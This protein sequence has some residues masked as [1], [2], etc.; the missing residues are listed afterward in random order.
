[1]KI[2]K[3]TN[4]LKKSNTIDGPKKLSLGSLYFIGSPVKMF[5]GSGIIA[6]PI[7]IKQD[8]ITFYFIC[9]Y[10]HHVLKSSNKSVVIFPLNR[11]KF[12]ATVIRI[13]N[14]RINREAVGIIFNAFAEKSTSMSKAISI[15]V[16]KH[17]I[18]FVDDTMSFSKDET[19][20]LKLHF[21]KRIINIGEWP[22]LAIKRWAAY[23]LVIEN[24]FLRCV[25]ESD[26]SHSKKNL[27][28][29]LQ[30]RHV[31]HTSENKPSAENRSDNEVTI[32]DIRVVSQDENNYYNC[33]INSQNEC[34]RVELPN[35]PYGEDDLPF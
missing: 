2:K 26:I 30:K 3:I 16:N 18:D 8:R 5:E 7:S 12:L 29:V 15:S 23:H 27:I 20:K 34:E 13:F 17:D 10:E 35:E 22:E 1:V 11:S 21:I 24:D 9:V 4:L 6:M 28:D 33:Y 19:D 14:T 31:S 25:C 32:S